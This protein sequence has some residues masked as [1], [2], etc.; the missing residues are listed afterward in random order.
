MAEDAGNGTEAVLSYE[1]EKERYEKR[2]ELN[3]LD[4]FATNDLNTKVNFDY[5][6]PL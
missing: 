5:Q 6:S 3:N 2:I 1:E 4:G